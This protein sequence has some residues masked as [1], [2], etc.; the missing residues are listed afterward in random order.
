MRIKHA[1]VMVLVLVFTVTESC[2]HN[3]YKVDIAGIKATVKIKR[4]EQD[5]FSGSPA[6]IVEDVPKLRD[7]YNGFLQLFSYVINIGNVNDSTWSLNLV[8]FCTDKLNNEVFDSTQKIFP[9]VAQFEKGLTDAF[10]HYLYYFPEKKIPGVYTCISGFNNSIITGDSA[11][12]IGLDRYLGSNSMYYPQLQ[13][14][15]YQILKMNPRNII[16]DCMYAWAASEW[17]YKS[18]SY[19]SNDVLSEMIHEGKLM[20]FVKCMLPETNDELIFGFTP[21]QLRFCVK[22]ENE[23]WQYLV[24]NNLLF[25]STQLT[26]RKLI[27]EAPFTSYFS[28]ESPGRAAVWIGFRIIESYMLKNKDTSL[29]DLMKTTDCQAILEKARYSPK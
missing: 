28:K 26:I 29:S 7:K 5:L 14:Y 20:Y 12:G 11:L 23:M 13:L 10:K 8:R 17:D 2:H 19:N 18:M 21:D 3:R 15:R 16:P 9:D 6:R 24:E 27:G 25:N 1:F 4:L 22:N